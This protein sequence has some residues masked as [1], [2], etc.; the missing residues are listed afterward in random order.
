[1]PDGGAV[2][3]PE[4]QS[5]SLCVCLSVED[6]QPPGEVGENGECLVVTNGWCKGELWNVLILPLC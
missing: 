2:H 6:V 1:M 3:A 4:G 5:A